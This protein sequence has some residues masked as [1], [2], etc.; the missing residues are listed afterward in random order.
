MFFNS[1]IISRKTKFTWIHDFNYL[2]Y[3]YFEQISK[4]STDKKQKYIDFIRYASINKRFQDIYF[5]DLNILYEF[6][7]WN[8][9]Q[10]SDSWAKYLWIMYM[11]TRNS[12]H[13][14]NVSISSHSIYEMKYRCFKKVYNF[15]KPIQHEIRPF[16]YVI[17]EPLEINSLRWSQ[18]KPLWCPKSS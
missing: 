12:R 2:K 9:M 6:S 17:N 16:K 7:I 18:T 11:L 14:I 1:K 10:T 4:I 8:L 13:I 5:I 15:L 3:L